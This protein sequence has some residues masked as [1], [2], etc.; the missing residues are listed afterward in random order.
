MRIQQQN[1]L[2]EITRDLAWLWD[3]LNLKARF[4]VLLGYI[5][6]IPIYDFP[7]LSSQM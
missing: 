4:G 5:D 2:K 1:L 3:T 6:F 7:G